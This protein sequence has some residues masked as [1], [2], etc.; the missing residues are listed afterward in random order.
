MISCAIYGNINVICFLHHCSLAIHPNKL[1]VATGQCA[2]HDKRE[3]KVSAREQIKNHRLGCCCFPFN[4]STH[5][6]E[7]LIS[8][9][10]LG[11]SDTDQS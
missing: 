9:V 1:I 11:G 6:F 4:L 3:G 8:S 5:P 10:D 7:V 2:G